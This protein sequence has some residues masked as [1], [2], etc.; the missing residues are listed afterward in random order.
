MFSHDKKALCRSSQPFIG[1]LSFGK[2]SQEDEALLD[3]IWKTNPNSK[4]LYIM[5]PRPK[6]NAIGNRAKGGIYNKERKKELFMV[7]KKERKK[8]RKKDNVFFFFRLKI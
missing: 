1:L 6:A 3:A 7:L 4:T 5:D 8:E 2:K